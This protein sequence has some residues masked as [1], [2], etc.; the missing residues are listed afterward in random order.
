MYSCLPV[1]GAAAAAAAA[2]DF[3]DAG[4]KSAAA[5]AAGSSSAGFDRFLRGGIL[6][7]IWKSERGKRFLITEPG[8]QNTYKNHNCS[9]LFHSTVFNSA[10]ILTSFPKSNQE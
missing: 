9:L 8:L 10:T 4:G 6:G 5:A 1:E 2:F 3:L 7:S